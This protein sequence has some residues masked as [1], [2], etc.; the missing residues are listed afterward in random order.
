MTYTVLS[1]EQL[2]HWYLLNI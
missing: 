2:L 1:T